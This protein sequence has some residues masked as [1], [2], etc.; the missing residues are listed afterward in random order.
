MKTSCL[1]LTFLIVAIA[2]AQNP[3]QHWLRYKTPEQAGWSSEQLAT[4]CRNSNANAV[5]L[6]QNGKIVYAYGEYWRRIKCHSMRKSF[7]SALYGIYVERGMIDTG[8]TIA[9]LGITNT[10]PLTEDEKQAKIVDL[11]TCRSGIYLRSGQESEEM[12]RSRPDRGSHPPGTYWYYNNWDFNAL[13]T[14]FRKV[15][16]RDIFEEFKSDIANPL[17]MEDFRLMDGVYEFEPPDTS[18]PGYL[19]KM[20]AR[21]AAR[22]GQLYLQNGTWNGKQIVP[23]HW[24]ERSTSSLSNTSTPGTTYGYLWWIVEDFQGVRMYA[25]MGHFGQRVCI[26]PSLD[27]VVV[28]NSESYSSNSVLDV[29]FVL[30]DLVLSSRIG[31]AVPQPESMPLEEPLPLPT[32]TMSAEHQRRY[33]G[34]YSVDGTPVTISQT[35][36]GLILTGYHYSYKFRLLPLSQGLFHVED[37]DLLLY[38][39]L[40]RRGLATKLEI[41]K[42]E[43]TQDLYRLIMERGMEAASKEFPSFKGRLRHKEELEFL[44]VQLARKGIPIVALRKLNA[45]CFP[46]SYKAQSDLKNELLKAGDL[47]AAARVFRQLL[48][49]LQGHKL[50]NTKTEWYATILRALASEPLLTEAEEGTFAGD[51]GYRHVVAEEGTLYYHTGNRATKRKLHKISDKRFAIDGTYNMY[52]EFGQDETGAVNR[53][54]GHYYRDSFDETYRTK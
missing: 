46:Y 53:I 12:V 32:A 54:I 4:V 38:F 43:A 41:H 6:V 20:S 16:A 47:N 2:S 3:G 42:S 52:I 21:D 23:R 25:A 37:I 49:S 28:I 15:T 19:F 11:L 8:K 51:Y 50:T 30:P 27:L 18:H 35:D 22:F 33:V 34:E 31:D 9:Q 7:L 39:G 1:L 48:D 17:Q 26:I 13:G 44:C 36:D 5:L 10:P 45:A 24:I 29:D 40:D 14:I